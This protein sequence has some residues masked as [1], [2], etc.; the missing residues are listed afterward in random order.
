MGRNTKGR[1]EKKGKKGKAER[2]GK[3]RDSI[4]A[5]LFLKYNVASLG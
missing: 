4:P 3:G 5:L 2:G 1:D